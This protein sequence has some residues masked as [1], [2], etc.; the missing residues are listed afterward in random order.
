MKDS[1]IGNHKSVLNLTL[2]AKWFYMINQ[3]IKKE[4]YREIKPHWNQRLLNKDGSFKK[5][6][7]IFFQNG[8]GYGIPCFFIECLDLKIGTS[9]PE[10]SNGIEQCYVF[11]LGK[12]MEPEEVFTDFCKK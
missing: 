1:I 2:K 8:Y 6:D 12:L 10:W 4:E 9:K 11:A 5:P 7:V 3:G